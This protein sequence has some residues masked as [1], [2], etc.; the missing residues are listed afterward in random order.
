MSTYTTAIKYEPTW[1]AFDDDDIDK[2]SID[3]KFRKRVEQFHVGLKSITAT[4]TYRLDGTDMTCAPQRFLI[5][6]GGKN[7]KPGIG[8]DELAR[9]VTAWAQDQCNEVDKGEV[10][11]RCMFYGDAADQGGSF[12][13]RGSFKLRPDDDDEPDKKPP[14]LAPVRPSTQVV[15]AVSRTAAT[16]MSPA[17]EAEAVQLIRTLGDQTRGVFAELQATVRQIREDFSGGMLAQGEAWTTF[18]QASNT[19]IERMG[20]ELEQARIEATKANARLIEMT[21]EHASQHEG[22]KKILAYAMDMFLSGMKSTWG[23]MSREMSWEREIMYQQF[24]GLAQ[25]YKKDNRGE[26]LKEYSPLLLAIAGQVMEKVGSKAHGQILQKIAVG[27]TEEEEEKEE[28]VAA[29]TPA[30][31]RPQPPHRPVAKQTVMGVPPGVDPAAHLKQNPVA[32]MFQLFGSLLKKDP[33]QVESIQKILG[34]KYELLDRAMSANDDAQARSSGV[35]FMTSLTEE[36]LRG[37][38]EQV[39][40]SEQ[41]KLFKDMHK[42]LFGNL[43]SP[44]P[45]ASV[46]ELRTFAKQTYGLSFPRTATRE[47]ILTALKKK[48]S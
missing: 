18:A 42:Q 17:I 47:D 4:P 24:E 1:E 38:L 5:K 45:K 43:P 12:Q 40:N 31:P 46:A 34:D 7:K 15:S 36:D 25:K 32:S 23:A 35:R 20:S 21:K 29:P 2:M 3:E 44:D 9:L 41:Q 28:T 30:K 27:I 48:D 6:G 11:Y 13:N 8:V 37:Q 16:P 14:P 19:Q 26:L 10:T 22:E 33:E 39:L